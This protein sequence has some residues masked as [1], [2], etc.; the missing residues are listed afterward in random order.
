METFAEDVKYV[1]KTNALEGKI[2][3]K[4]SEFQAL[5]ARKGTNTLAKELFHKNLSKYQIENLYQYYKMILLSL[6]QYYKM[7]LLSFL[8]TFYM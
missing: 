4:D 2:S 8:V 6:Y 5:N 1:I 7:M 3:I